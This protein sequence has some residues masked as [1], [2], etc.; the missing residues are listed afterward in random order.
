[1]KNKT[2][3]LFYHGS[4]DDQLLLENTRKTYDV[5]WNNGIGFNLEVEEG[6]G[7]FIS[8]KEEELVS[9][10]FEKHMI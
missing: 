5:L 3:V 4:D 10:F 8:A 1:M 6:H 9:K 2:P 7:H